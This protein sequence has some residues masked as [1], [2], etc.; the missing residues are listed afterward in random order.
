MNRHCITQEQIITTFI[1]Q[2]GVPK[3]KT[4]EEFSEKEKEA[5]FHFL[6]KNDEDDDALD[7]ATRWFNCTQMTLLLLIVEHEQK[8]GNLKI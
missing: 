4:S 7:F 6:E 8:D 2:L 3:K 5:L 1:T